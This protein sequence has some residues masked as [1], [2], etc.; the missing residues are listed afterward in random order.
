M[1]YCIGN[2]Q[3]LEQKFEK[4]FGLRPNYTCY[5]NCKPI[6]CHN[7]L[8][9]ENSKPKCCMYDGLCLSCYTSFGKIYFYIQKECSSC[10][11]IKTCVLLKCNH[12][13]CV[14]CYRTKINIPVFPYSDKVQQEYWEQPGHIKWHTELPLVRLWLQK[15]DEWDKFKKEYKCKICK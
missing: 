10:L 13:V 1:E 12:Y 14:E 7:Y 5:F 3:C 11:Y 4:T 8:L 2:G 15:W 6:Q 9:C